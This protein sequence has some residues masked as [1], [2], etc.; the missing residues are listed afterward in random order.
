MPG[1]TGGFPFGQPGVYTETITGS[2]NVDIVDTSQ[3]LF[4]VVATEGVVALD[5][6]LSPFWSPQFFGNGNFDLQAFLGDTAQEGTL[7]V[8]YQFIPAPSAAALAGIAGL[9]GIRRRR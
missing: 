4:D 7:T 5:A 2:L 9:A 8:E 3:L 6:S 1:G